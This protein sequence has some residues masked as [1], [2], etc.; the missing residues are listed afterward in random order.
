[1]SNSFVSD[2]ISKCVGN[3]KST[4]AQICA[5]AESDLNKIEEKIKKIE[6]LRTL[7]SNLRKVL[8][9]IGGNKYKR[10][11]KSS[12]MMNDFS[13]PA[14][15]LGSDMRAMCKGVCDFIAKQ[16]RGM[17]A[18][19]VMDAVADKSR[20]REVYHAIQW[21]QEHGILKHDEKD[22]VKFIYKGD[23]WGDRIKL[24]Q[25]KQGSVSQENK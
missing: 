13:I 20:S 3:G 24:E 22:F 1:M 18:R 17:I 5:V 9:Q 8:R 10:R 25:D 12:I 15:D 21:L 19:E 4:P 14:D 6:S 2:F 7:Q 23:A 16:N 11:R